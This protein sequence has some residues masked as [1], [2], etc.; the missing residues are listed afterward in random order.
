MRPGRQ[1]LTAIT[2]NNGSVVDTVNNGSGNVI[3]DH[4]VYDSFG[5]TVSQTN[6]AD[7]MLM[8]FDGY[9]QTSGDASVGL[10][11]ANA[12]Y[13]SPSLGR[14]ISQDPSGFAAGNTNLYRV[15]GNHPT[16]ATDPTGLYEG[17]SAFTQGTG[18]YSNGGGSS[19]LI[20]P[21]LNLG[22]GSGSS[23]AG[24]SNSFTGSSPVSL[25]N[26]TSTAFGGNGPI[27]APTSNIAPFASGLGGSGSYGSGNNSIAFNLGVAGVSGSSALNTFENN[28]SFSSPSTYLPS[29]DP[30][31][32]FSPS[33]IVQVPGGMNDPVAALPNTTPSPTSWWGQFASAF[34]WQAGQAL[35]GAGQAAANTL[36][37]PV[38]AYN[39]A[40]NA[41]ASVMYQNLQ[42]G[43]NSLT[44]LGAGLSYDVNSAV[45]SGQ[46]LQGVY[47]VNLASDQNL[48]G[49]QRAQYI[50]GGSGQLGLTAAWLGSSYNGAA[51][52]NSFQLSK[53]L[54]DLTPIEVKVIQSIVDK[55]GIPLKVGGSAASAT[56]SLGSDIDYIAAPED[57]PKW[58][59][60]APQL[61]GIDLSHGILPESPYGPNWGTGIE[62]KPGVPPK[63][64]KG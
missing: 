22:T 6:A 1:F 40:V 32:V 8:G 2:D 19:S 28:Y 24:G 62:F 50:I 63:L 61:P 39:N 14:F 37:R 11:Y 56:R 35:Y 9:V 54:G 13:Y 18:G 25:T 36:T 30:S 44:E 42:F 60:V 34:Y 5:N 27:T 20:A 26:P 31:S 4:I 23:N 43:G 15:V 53:P 49:M 58:D 52:L 21:W 51:G 48:T 46:I 57:I 12:R 16:Y 7:A 59:Q 10:Y 3:L 41:N 47:G 55:A 17:G 38:V 64:I 45:G 29:N 33:S